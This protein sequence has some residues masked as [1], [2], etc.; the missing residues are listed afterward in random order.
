MG[1]LRGRPKLTP[2]AREFRDEIARQLRAALTSGGI[3]VKHAAERLGVSR[4]AFHQYLSG[5]ATP[6]PET[7]AR[8]MDL[9]DIRPSYRGEIIAK[10]ALGYPLGRS[11]ASPAQLSLETLFDVPQECHNENL[12]VT[13][14]RSR[15]SM[16]QVT[17]RMK[18]ANSEGSRRT[19]GVRTAG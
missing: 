7:L 3:T 6:Y 10:G 19:R 17:I 9:W 13:L 16:L 14:Q 11:E 2:A 1:S 5:K 12:T 8:A 4:Q 18:K 15:G